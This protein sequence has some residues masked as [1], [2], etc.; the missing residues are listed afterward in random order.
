MSRKSKGQIAGNR[1][2]RQSLAIFLAFALVVGLAPVM[3]DTE[4]K[5]YADS[6]WDAEDEIALVVTG[7]GV[8]LKPEAS[9]TD[10][11][12]E[13]QASLSNERAYTLSELQS[14]A[15]V[16]R[17]FSARNS[18]GTPFQQLVKGIDLDSI[19]EASGFDPGISGD[20]TVNT[21][22]YAK[23]GNLYDSPLPHYGNTER[24]YYAD[25]ANPDTPENPGVSVK[26]VL[27]FEAA[28]IE[29]ANGIDDV[30][31]DSSDLIPIAA[32]DRPRLYVGQLDRDNANTKL[33]NKNVQFVLAGDIVEENSVN[34]F[35]KTFTRAQ[36]M[37]MDRVTF[38]YQYEKSGGAIGTEKVRGVALVD[39]LDATKEPLQDY[40]TVIISPADDNA[41]GDYS[42]RVTVGEIRNGSN[43]YMLAYEYFDEDS[44]EWIP[45]Y[46]KNKK[47]TIF[48][49]LKLFGGLNQ[50]T[51]YYSQPNKMINNI[52]LDQGAS[53]F[54]HMTYH[55]GG[56]LSAH[57]APD[58]ITSATLTVEG[59]GLDGT[60]PVLI[61][62]L[63][64]TDDSNV[65]RGNYEDG[66]GEYTYEGVKVDSLVDGLVNSKIVKLSNDIKVI[67]KNRWRQN[68]AE[69]SYA[70]L[71]DAQTPVILAW[72]ISDGTTTAPFVFDDSA[73]SK[74][75]PYKSLGIDDGCLKLVYDRNDPAL[76]SVSGPDE[77]KSVAY[78]YVEN[79]SGAPGF[80]HTTAANDAYNN[81]ANTEYIVSF[82]G[83]VLGRE[84]N[85]TVRELEDMVLYKEG[86]GELE[87]GSMGHRAEYN[88]S[89]TTY[90]YVNEYEGIKLWDLLTTKL[91]VDKDTYKDDDAT[92]VSFAAWDHYKTSAVF[93]MKQLA[94]PDL[95]YFYEKSPLDM[96]TDRPTKEQLATEEY[97]PDNQEGDWERDDN[98]YPVK[99]GYPVVLAYGVNGYPYVKKS[100]M[101]GYAGGLKNDGGPL[102]VIF[103][104]TNG[105]NRSNPSSP[106]NY[107]YF[108]NNGSNQLQRVQEVYV[109]DDTR[110]NTHYQNPTYQ[111]MAETSD[112]LVVEIIQADGTKDTHRFTL[113]QLEEILYGEGVAPIDRAERREKAFYFYKVAGGG[114]KI[115]DLF[116][117][118]NLSYLLFEAIG[119]Q[120]TLGTVSFYSG[121]NLQGDPVNLSDIDFEGYNSEN[122]TDGLKMMVAFAKNGYPMVAANGDT[123]YVGTD[124][125]TGKTI[126]NSDGPLMLITPQTAEEK[127]EGKLGNLAGVRNLK[128]IVVNLEED[129]Y[130]HTGATYGVYGDQ[131]VSF[132]GGVK[133]EGVTL[134]VSDIEKLQKYLVTDT[135]KIGGNENRYRGI[136]LKGLLF[137]SQVSASSLLS[138]VTI[139]NDQGD[140]YVIKAKDLTSGI[141]GKPVILGYGIGSSDPG[142][143]PAD[144][145]PLV[146]DNTSA[147]YEPEYGNAG[148]PVRLLIHNGST[149]ECIEN[150]SEIF[151][152]VA[153]VDGWTH[154]FGVYEDYANMP[155]LRVSGSE[156]S[157]TRDF[158][159]GELE[160]LPSS[161]K[162]FDQ[163]MMGNNVYVQGI[164]LWKFLDEYIGL[165]DGVSL[166]GITVYANDGYATSFNASQ[167]KNGVNGKPILIAYG[168]GPTSSSGLPLVAG[169]DTTDIKPGYDPNVGNAFGP[170]RII[171]HD[172]TGWCAKWL[173]NIVVGSG[174]HE[175]PEIQSDVFTVSG[176]ELAV[177]KTYTIAQLAAL[178]ETSATYSHFVKDVGTVTDDATG[179]LLKDVLSEAGVYGDQYVYNVKT[180]DNTTNPAYRDITRADI[181]RDSYLLA[182]KVNGSDI[183]DKDK[184]GAEAIFRIY[185]NFDDGSSWKNRLTSIVGIEAIDQ[186]SNEVVFSVTV[187]G[188]VVNELTRN[189]LVKINTPVATKTFGSDTVSGIS[190]VDLFD[191]LGMKNGASKITVKDGNGEITELKDKT[192]NEIGQHFLAWKVGDAFIADKIGENVYPLRLYA[193]ASQVY[194]GITGVIADP[195]Y[196]WIYDKLG[197]IV[198]A[199][200][201][202][203]VSD[204]EGGF[205]AGTTSGLYHIDNAGAVTKPYTKANGKRKVDW[206]IDVAPDDAGGLWISQG[207][208]YTA[209]ENHGLVYIDGTGNSTFYTTG[210]TGGKLPNDYV[211]AL[212]V[213]K[214]GNVWIG[215]FGGLTKYNPT[216]DTW[217]TWTKDDGL[218][219]LSVNT[220]VLDDK[221]GVWIGCYPNGEQGG[222]QPP[223]TG[224]YAYLANDGTLTSWYYD[225]QTNTELN[226]YLLGDFWTRGI[227]VDASGGAWIVRSGAAPMYFNNPAYYNIDISE[228]VGGRLDYISPD[229]NT[230]THYT[231]RELIEAID[232]GIFAGTGGSAGATPE[233]R[234][235]AVDGQGGLWLGT[236]GLGV[237]HVKNFG[238]TEGHYYSRHYDWKSDDADNVYFIDVM[239]DGTVISGSNGGFAAKQFAEVSAD[240]GLKSL[241]ADVGYLSPS[242]DK[243][244]LEYLLSIPAGVDSVSF[245]AT[246]LAKG[247]EITFNGK[248][249]STIA[250]DEDETAVEIKVSVGAKDKAYSVKIL[251]ESPVTA[252][253]PVN[254]EDVNKPISVIATE[255][256]AYLITNGTTLPAIMAKTIVGRG[257]AEVLFSQGTGITAPQGWDRKLYLPS[258]LATNSV[259]VNGAKR[260]DAVVSVGST[261]DALGFD[262][263]FR[264]LLPGMGGKSLGFI[265]AGGNDVLPVTYA[266]AKDD[267]AALPADK[268][269]GYILVDNVDVAIWSRLAGTFVAFVQ[270]S[271]SGTPQEEYVLIVDGPGV[272]SEKGYTLEQLQ[273]WKD[274]FTGYYRWR[275]SYGTTGGEMHTGIK[276][277]ALL[278]ASGLT[279]N[280]KSVTVAASDYER[281]FNLGDGELGVDKVYPNNLYIILELDS[282]GELQ[283]IVPQENSDDV[284][285]PFWVRGIERITVNVEKV[286]PG[287]GTPGKGELEAEETTPED[288]EIPVGRT[289]TTVLTLPVDITDGLATGTVSGNDINRAIDEIKDKAGDDPGAKGVIQIN[290]DNPE[291]K[292]VKRSEI[293]LPMASVRALAGE[294]NI[295]VVI[296]TG[297][298]QIILDP[299]LLGNLSLHSGNLLK[300]IV[301]N[302][303]G[304]SLGSDE[305]QLVGDRPIVDIY[306]TIDGKMISEF[307][308]MTIKAAIPYEAA[309]GEE[310]ENLV[311]IFL[312]GPE[313]GKPVKLSL[314]SPATK[315]MLVRTSHLSL[316]GVAHR[317]VTF[318]DIG[319]HWAKKS[320]EFLAVRNV[321]QGKGADR[322]D[323]EGS[324]TRAE[325]VVMLANSVDGIDVTGAKNAGFDD[326]M[327]GSWYADYINWAVSMGIVK[328]YGDGRFGPNDKITREQ[329]A[330]MTDNFIN[331]MS[332]RPDVVNEKMEFQDSANISDWSKAA[333]GRVQQYG[334]INGHPDGSFAPRATATRA[335]AAVIIKGYIES[336]LR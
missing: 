80:K 275:N 282:R 249:D 16:E 217:T 325:F 64:E 92:L 324:V 39:L 305:E 168:I 254:A 188:E 156:I 264:L 163:Y 9:S 132:T 89:N 210:N 81:P 274:K 75:E 18:G 143:A 140:E 109:G 299:A 86:T 336:V 227:A 238:E 150:V 256:G 209:D 84:V 208:T 145:K 26:P 29:N 193:S 98:N 10:E 52:M 248:A 180:T 219:A 289:I 317:V 106:E 315:E 13:V 303:D 186:F 236:S 36:L 279:D 82:G 222:L 14:M 266:L 271:G 221:G 224:G 11:M 276:L 214:E 4:W 288:G 273:N 135:Y 63:E 196:N 126:K 195:V 284:N 125:V 42:S 27:A 318:G 38:T 70:N 1:F 215:S 95:F 255:N 298:G 120:G 245:E 69:I 105:M 285:K 244:V 292:E 144:G 182:Y 45:T 50:T 128:K 114:S 203:I 17:N 191:S 94:H 127:A 316:Y 235:V 323:P 199:S 51:G 138:E 104:K 310:E 252:D 108:Y 333:V 90:W 67:F 171:V 272:K 47:G 147:G 122:G 21:L 326:V 253:N 297:V 107:A 40:Y 332:A 154:S 232:E 25:L 173:N 269:Y 260:V 277:S 313:K 48:G 23:N 229:K 15:Q 228:C 62:E 54:K 56:E 141:S 263:P 178:G 8:V 335:Q 261:E 34:V 290:A 101:E 309:A 76:S 226:E 72:G 116:E 250:C 201:R 223:F 85:F 139:K 155:A 110:Y 102:K 243:D 123:G 133:N 233:I 28:E 268:D 307:G 2:L 53:L 198:P 267:G 103:G 46:D 331:A 246:A 300:I 169:N 262:K 184:A 213:D 119:M 57:F 322:F 58:S 157:Q 24:Y 88:L 314:Y 162:V 185:R 207:W 302:V 312:D 270:D 200:V 149:G 286:I 20:V 283:L 19:L 179:V 134:K 278:R 259:T 234:S 239:P 87:D 146:P 159:V 218:P 65:W 79:I 129:N 320:I 142:A 66:R 113:K 96:G 183:L 327:M 306:L 247:S 257:S 240:A 124:A 301:E 231:G 202:N 68:V 175:E 291:G 71:K 189:E 287:S 137:S 158:T 160:S 3:P 176:N 100:D 330:L 77:F 5:A 265:P 37:K 60:T 115:Q 237:F 166:T 164:D 78:V 153:E 31:P 328:G 43:H 258:V 131:E 211:Q 304:G 172:N 206:V 30:I 91:G 311:V 73:I 148:G 197:S 295:S 99:K 118:V 93:S 187:D 281:N 55:G 177:E 117:G 204:E 59:P 167:V 111:Y 152:D 194:N 192:I 12:A 170:I 7:D 33:S 32:K 74:Q 151:V 225:A 241:A 112:A 136:D 190:L 41:S 329:M 280:A 165:K 321:V 22:S 44:E 293:G 6:S 220:I 61:R 216:D 242:F 294:G 174:A 83:S 251:K 205:W 161:Y 334:I 130:A 319:V 212:E 181:E 121:D 230:V 35:G 97:Q 308:G 49:A 296:N